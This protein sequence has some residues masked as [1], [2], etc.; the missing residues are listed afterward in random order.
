[1]DKLLR[2][3]A[4]CPSVNQVSARHK[5]TLKTSQSVV[6][7]YIVLYSAVTI[8]SYYQS[9]LCTGKVDEGQGCSYWWWFY[10]LGEQGY[11][12][13]LH[14]LFHIFYSTY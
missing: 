14:F 3:V 8:S 4:L 1:M 5:K 6:N 10:S 12:N 13:T 2:I 9:E 7:I 11:E